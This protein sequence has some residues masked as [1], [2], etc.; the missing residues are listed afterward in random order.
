MSVQ[1]FAFGSNGSGQLGI[2]CL[3]D[4]A[5]PTICSIVSSGDE[6]IHDTLN[7]RRLQVK[8]G[9][10][11]TY[12]VARN[13]DVY[14]AGKLD[15]ESSQS[16][17]GDQE[18]F[19][20]FTRLNSDEYGTV[21]LCSA[22]WSAA[23]FVTSSNRISAIGTGYKGELGLGTATLFTKSPVELSCFLPDKALVVDIAS[24]VSH[25]ALVT[26]DGDVY[27]WGN[28]RKGQL[29][30]PSGYIWNPRK[31]D[32]IDFKI[33]RAVC[34]R[35]FTFLA[36]DSESGR[37]LVFGS[38]KWQIRSSA[39]K[40]IR[41][42]KDVQ[43]SWG[44]LFLLSQDDLMLSWGRNDCGQLAPSGLPPVWRMAVGSEHVLAVTK[45]G[46]VVCWG[47]GE[48]GNCGEDLDSD[49]NVNGTWKP[50]CPP[51]SEPASSVI[52]VAAGCATSFILKV[53]PESR[54]L[55]F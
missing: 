17:T 39:P 18:S 27:G 7:G 11:V 53:L 23:F 9:G 35:E 32:G 51:S 42:W 55:P 48:H 2:G 20:T 47:W 40:D 45:E 15:G 12:I 29:G 46:G 52:G 30:E 36:G 26:S 24:S 44:S 16:L 50:I 14:K 31:I 34:G 3:E 6:D 13:G 10:S 4:V 43:A 22:T 33:V 38:N 49:G 5:K 41:G 21:R 1:L 54:T 8:A 28:G 19:S 37:Y 25:T